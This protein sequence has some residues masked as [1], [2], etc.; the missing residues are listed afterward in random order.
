[1]KIYL[2]KKKTPHTPP[3]WHQAFSLDSLCSVILLQMLQMPQEL[4]LT[5]LFTLFLAITF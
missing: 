1:M 2:K 3:H 5:L 4:D